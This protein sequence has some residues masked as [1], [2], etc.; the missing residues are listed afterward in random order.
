LRLLHSWELANWFYNKVLDFAG[1]SFPLMEEADQYWAYYASPVHDRI[2]GA[3][4][5]LAIGDALGAPV[6][7]ADRGTFER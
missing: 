7:F 6:E 5:G 2:A 1:D 4:V 3:F